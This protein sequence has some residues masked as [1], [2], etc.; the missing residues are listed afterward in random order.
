MREI[1]SKEYVDILMKSSSDQ[2]RLGV[3][4]LMSQIRSYNSEVSD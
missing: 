1:S 3:I 4:N 2:N